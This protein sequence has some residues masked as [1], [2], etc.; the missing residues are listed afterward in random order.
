MFRAHVGLNYAAVF[1][2]SVFAGTLPPTV[3][4]RGLQTYRRFADSALVIELRVFGTELGGALSGYL[5]RAG[6]AYNCGRFYHRN[7]RESS[8]SRA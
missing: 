7:V 1:N 2:G 4:T 3:G 6:L 8:I 5:K